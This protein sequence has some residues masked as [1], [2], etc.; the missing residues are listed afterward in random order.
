MALRELELHPQTDLCLVDLVM[1]SSVSDGAA[2]ARY[3]KT[4]MPDCLRMVL[5]ARAD[6]IQARDVDPREPWPDG[7]NCPPDQAV[8]V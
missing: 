1:P 5:A 2:F 7:R 6:M 4:E 8:S 3:I